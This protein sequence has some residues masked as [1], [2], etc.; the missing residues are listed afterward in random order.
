MVGCLWLQHGLTHFTPCETI[1]FIFSSWEIEIKSQKHLHATCCRLSDW[2]KYREMI[3]FIWILWNIKADSCGVVSILCLPVCGRQ[4]VPLYSWEHGCYLDPVWVWTGRRWVGLL[5]CVVHINKA[6]VCRRQTDERLLKLTFKH[7][8]W[9]V[10]LFPR[11]MTLRRQRTQQTLRL[12]MARVQRET[13]SS[14][15]VFIASFRWGG[16]P[17]H[18]SPAKSYRF[19]KFSW[20]CA[21]ATPSVLVPRLTAV[22]LFEGTH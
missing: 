9:M 18:C 6:T 8:S 7:V 22:C 21:N 13:L 3:L 16:Y 10:K 17:H 14:H 2:H 12:V 4:R 19:S 11:L 1:K 5:A 20:S 15:L